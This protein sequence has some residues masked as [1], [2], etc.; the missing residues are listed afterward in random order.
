MNNSPALALALAFI[1][2][3]AVLTVTVIVRTGPDI[4][5]VVSLVVLGLFTLGIVSAIRGAGR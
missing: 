2:A 1:L 3:M 5:S 4:L